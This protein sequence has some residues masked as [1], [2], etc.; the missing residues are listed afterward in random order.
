MEVCET[1]HDNGTHCLSGKGA[2]SKPVQVYVSTHVRESGSGRWVPVLNQ[3]RQY[4]RW[5]DGYAG[6]P[7]SP[8][9]FSPDCGTQLEA[10]FQG[11]GTGN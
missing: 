3:S 1:L 2:P 7:I 5:M 9:T 10:A 11:L 4:P 6:H 8:A